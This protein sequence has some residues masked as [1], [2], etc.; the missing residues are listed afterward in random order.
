VTGVVGGTG[1][2]GV[3]LE[4]G[5]VIKEESIKVEEEA[6]VKHEIPQAVPFPPITTEPEV[7]LWDVCGCGRCCV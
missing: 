4:E 5:I 1:E 2:G 6:D 7:R 3:E